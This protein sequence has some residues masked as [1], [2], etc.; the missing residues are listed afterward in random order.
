M[1]PDAKTP[2]RGW[3]KAAR[4]ARRGILGSAVLA[5]S[6][7]VFTSS[8]TAS[9]QAVDYIG[10]SGSGSRGG[11]F[12]Y[13][14]PGV[15]VNN[16]GVGGVP[17][18]TI[19]AT[20]GGSFDDP[21]ERGNRI[22]RF[23]R[24]DNGTPDDTVDDTYQFVSAWGAGVNTGGT[25]FEICTVA[26]ECR[27]GS[28]IGGNGTP[29]GDGSLN[30]PSGIA[31]DQD[32][33]NVYVSDS[34]P[35]RTQDD[36][37]RINVYSATGEFLRSFGWDVVESGP[38]D[39]GTGFEVCEAVVDVCK[40]GTTGSG[41]GQ[42]GSSPSG[43]D[44]PEG[45]AVSQ[46]DG[47]PA[48]GIVF[49][50]DQGNNR[51]DTFGLDGSSPSSF[52]SSAV[53]GPRA[54]IQ[55]AVDSRGIVYASNTKGG[56]ETER[57]DT[58]NADGSGIGFLAPIT[59]RSGA[60]AIDPD[61]D[62][63]GPGTDVLY[64][65]ESTV[66]QFG[67]INEPGLTAP[68]VAPDDVLGTNGVFEFAR[69]MATEASTGRVYVAAFK[70]STTASGGGPGIYV[71]DNVGAPPTATLDSLSGETSHSV[72]AHLTIDPNGPPATSYHLEYSLDGSTWESTPQVTLGAQE[73]PQSIAVTI[74]PPGAGLLPSSSYQVRLSAGRLLTEP[75]VTP[76]LTF[77]TLGAP[78][79]VETTGSPVRTATTVRFDGRVDPSN[80][81]A[82]YYFEYGDEG[83]CD[84]HPCTAS[85]AQPAGSGVTI[86]LVSQQVE[87][88]Q[89][90][91]TYSYRVVADNGDASGPVFGADMTVSTRASDAPL[92]H[93]HVAG[94]TGSDRGYEQVSLPDLSGN[95]ASEA[96]AISDDGDR[97]LYRVHGGNPV[98]NTG[99]AFNQLFAE[100]T[101]SGWQTRDI[102]PAR[103][104]LVAAGWQGIYGKSDLSSLASLNNN[105]G[106]GDLAAFRISP[107]GP[108][109]K[110]FETKAS[111]YPTFGVSDDASRMVMLLKSQLYDVTSGTPQLLSTVAGGTTPA[112]VKES[113][114]FGY[115]LNVLFRAPHWLSANGDL[116]FFPS[117]GPCGSAG[118]AQLY[119]REIEA[120]QTKLISGPPVSGPSCGAA[121]IRSTATAA[122][123]WTRS[124]LSAADS[125]PSGCGSS[126]G[127]DGDVY[128]YDLADGS[129]DCVTC[130][131]PGLAADVIANPQSP[132]QGVA[133]AEDG[134]RVYFNSPK[135]LLP[136]A[137]AGIYRVDVASGNL[138][139]VGT[140]GQVGS[141]VELGQAL[142]PD[143]AVLIFTSGNP[144]LNALGGQQN[145]GTTQYYR[146][147]DRDRSLNCV[148]CPQDD[149]DAAAGVQ[150]QLVGDVIHTGPNITPVSDDGSVFA[151]AT[152]TP[153][154]KA[155][156]NTPGPGGNPRSG[157]DIYEWRDG[158]LLLVSDGL[159]NWPA[160]E[161]GIQVPV[162]DGVGRSGRDL[163]FTA[164]AQYTPDALDGFARLY[165][166]RIG[167]GFEFPTPPK[168][169][170][171]EV[172][173]GTPKGAPEEAAP[174]TRGF[175]GPGNA[176]PHHSKPH[177]KPH[178]KKKHH[179][180][181]H[182]RTNNGRRAAR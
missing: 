76:A 140:G 166:A 6:L 72:V 58:K 114:A 148:S 105:L 91:T 151:F 156:Q 177:K 165:D 112:C 167:G 125:V 90:G 66:S 80:A 74:D 77:S 11:E 24:N 15:A 54:P 180:K 3:V 36:N 108:A 173:Q 96:L 29:A 30:K 101:A 5:L 45:I 179:K 20:D 130:V 33:G 113:N 94:P 46:P 21:N 85:A 73:D 133:V 57:Y 159:T 163:Y 60:L 153:L 104:D 1:A 142:T 69:A 17:V 169:C 178:H 155:D 99:S 71:L 110:V 84:S 81:P 59:G 86:E 14:P 136:G 160:T 176:Q 127:P 9:K 34:S 37:F 162:V 22:Q 79:R 31:V 56:G 8:A 93:G 132:A 102:Y 2:T 49:L 123:F 131:V 75:I 117:S 51:V 118:E 7:A 88:L 65:G 164:A 23:Q 39:S 147:D 41:I 107:D 146:Y 149:Q 44:S 40:A 137:A 12:T 19:Y 4:S 116:A 111:E 28:G 67:P 182:H 115:P 100:R 103:T 121:F 126:L 171:L 128:R 18:G 119:V 154:V 35:R 143:G 82:S 61:P 106:V 139:F 98:S 150:P 134:S 89:P 38:D 168:P 135:A 161:T 175:S 83:P 124:R 25:A 50:G 158:R 43:E 32:T 92:S 78:P 87:G 26:P 52:G 120:E 70:Q 172:C 170:P 138:A 144:N 141:E 55:I 53:F 10:G 174:A 64:V 16:T 97:V 27:R 152:P 129:L 42:L 145:G 13:A 157:T 109:S 68:P 122:F 62:G 63:P 47:N 95:P 181:K 48:T